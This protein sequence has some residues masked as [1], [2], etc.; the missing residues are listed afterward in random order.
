MNTND[1]TEYMEFF[2]GLIIKQFPDG[3]TATITEQFRHGLTDK[4]IEAGIVAFGKFLRKL[5]NKISEG[6]EILMCKKRAKKAYDREDFFNHPYYPILNSIAWNL[7]RLGQKATSRLETTPCK[8]LVIDDMTKAHEHFYLEANEE[9]RNVYRTLIA[10][11]FRFNGVDFLTDDVF[12]K[13]SSLVIEHEDED[14]VIGVKL[15]AEALDNVKNN[16]IKPHNVVLRGDFYPLVNNKP[17]AQVLYLHDFVFS[18]PPKAR[19][20][21]VEADELLTDSGCQVV[22]RKNNFGSNVAFVYTMKKGRKK[23]EICKIDIDIISCHITLDGNSYTPDE[24]TG[25]E[26]LKNQLA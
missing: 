4:E 15:I 24:I 6:D 20:W 5:F 17:S 7:Y 9:T 12:H 19:E 18:Q 22:G 13:P 14:V 16:S 8:R 26:L 23:V 2:K 25:F 11:G 21:L 3:F 1:L 10:L